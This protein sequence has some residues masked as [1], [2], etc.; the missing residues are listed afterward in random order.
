MF[1][2]PTLDW[3]YSMLCMNIQNI[4]HLCIEIY[5]DA[6]LESINVIYTIE[7]V[8]FIATCRYIYYNI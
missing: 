6:K 7:Y 5:V 3:L 2:K 1:I 4:E 8:I